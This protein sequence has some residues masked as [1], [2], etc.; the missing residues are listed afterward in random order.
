MESDVLAIALSNE[1]RVYSPHSFPGM[2]SSPPIIEA[3]KLQGV[4][5]ITRGSSDVHD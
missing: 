4:R 5:L 1:F 2:L 3:F